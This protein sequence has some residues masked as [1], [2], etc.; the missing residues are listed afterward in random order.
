MSKSMMLAAAIVVMAAIAAV[1]GASVLG[2][3]AHKDPGASVGAVDPAQMMR[4]AKDLPA[5]CCIDP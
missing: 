3:F 4:Q 1:M 2:A 5:L